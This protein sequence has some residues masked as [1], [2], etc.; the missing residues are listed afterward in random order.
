MSKEYCLVFPQEIIIANGEH[1]SHWEFSFTATSELF[2]WS[3]VLGIF[4]SLYNL[5]AFFVDN[6]IT[7]TEARARL[8]TDIEKKLE[9][10]L[11]AICC[12]IHK[13]K[14]LFIE[15]TMKSTIA[16][17][18]QEGKLRANHYQDLPRIEFVKINCPRDNM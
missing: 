10:V 12:S 13:N 9:K 17:W 2:C 5:E 7:N 4:N 6:A 1:Y 18:G 16:F 3:S 11:H 15:D 14:F 8:V